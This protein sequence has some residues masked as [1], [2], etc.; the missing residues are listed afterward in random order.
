MG[1]IPVGSCEDEVKQHSRTVVAQTGFT[2]NVAF[3]S[4]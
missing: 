3:Y 4:S 1:L 2:G